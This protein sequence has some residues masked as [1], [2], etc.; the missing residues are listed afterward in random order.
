MNFAAV[1]E[2][3]RRR[4]PKRAPYRSPACTAW[5]LGGCATLRPFPPPVRTPGSSYH[6][7]RRR[8]THPRHR[9]LRPLLRVSIVS[10]AV[11]SPTLPR[12]CELLPDPVSPTARLRTASFRFIDLSTSSQPPAS[13][14]RCADAASSHISH[15]RS[16]ANSTPAPAASTD[17]SGGSAGDIIK[18]SG[19]VMVLGAAGLF[20]LRGTGVSPSLR[21]TSRLKAGTRTWLPAHATAFRPSA[22]QSPAL[23]ARSGRSVSY[24]RKQASTMSRDPVPASDHAAPARR[25]RSYCWKATDLGGCG[26]RCRPGIRLDLPQRR[27]GACPAAAADAPMSGSATIHHCCLKAALCCACGWRNRDERRQRSTVPLRL[28]CSPRIDIPTSTRWALVLRALHP[29]ADAVVIISADLGGCSSFDS[30]RRGLR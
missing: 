7:G 24:Y 1:E 23:M 20:M 28:A 14:L 29:L 19:F 5:L 27:D 22:R 6:G 15:W 21:L 8:S 25:T 26:G 12:R 18:C 10:S 16:P 13:S 11:S 2:T 30:S 4:L 17:A 3:S 9:H